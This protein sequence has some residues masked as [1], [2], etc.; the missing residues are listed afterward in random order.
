[1][2]Y[3]RE[4]LP[5]FFFCPIC[6]QKFYQYLRQGSVGLHVEMK[7]ANNSLQYGIT[8]GLHSM[9]CF[10][11]YR[12]RQDR[13]NFYPYNYIYGQSAFSFSIAASVPTEM[14]PSVCPFFLQCSLAIHKT[15]SYIYEE[16]I[17]ITQI[18]VQSFGTHLY[19]VRHK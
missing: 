12:S 4:F 14:L 17:I 13:H 18:I 7:R 3:K 16:C 10:R 9:I 8:G 19:T 11:R 2:S 5:Q 6:R 1:M 15:T